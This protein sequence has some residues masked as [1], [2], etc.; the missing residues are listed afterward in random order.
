MNLDL[1][2]EKNLNNQLTNDI[3]NNEI[4]KNQNDFIG[5]MFKNAI[6]FGVDLGLKSLLPDLIEDQVIDIKNSILEGG[7]KEG[8]NTLMKKVNEFKNSITGIFTGNFNNI[9]E[10]NTAT[11]QG[12]IIKTVSKGL[13]KG[14]DAGVKSGIIPKS[15]GGILKAG[16]TTMLNEFSNSLESQMRKE[17]QKFDTLND[18]NKKWYDALD[19][20]DFD[21][22]TKYTEKISALSKDL[23][24]F[25]NIINETKKIEELHNFIK[26]NN[27][28]DFAV[29]A[30]G[31]LMKLD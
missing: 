28:F 6:N 30:D 26:E 24:K 13:S 19:Q 14:I 1:I 21:K 22:M 8:V 17:I 9:Q 29:G 3:K 31:A 10:I 4:S 11:K 7:F 18:L 23:V 2:S 12:G 16:K 25:S 20:R 5:N 15:I 27:S